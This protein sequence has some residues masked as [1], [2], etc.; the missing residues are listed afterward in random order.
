MKTSL[1][2]FRVFSVTYTLS[3][4]PFLRPIFLN[5]FSVSGATAPSR[6]LMKSFVFGGAGAPRK[7]APSGPRQDP[8]GIQIPRGAAARQYPTGGISRIYD[9]HCALLEGAYNCVSAK[10]HWSRKLYFWWA[11]EEKHYGEGGCMDGRCSD[12]HDGNIIRS[13]REKRK[14]GTNMVSGKIRFDGATD[15][16]S[17]RPRPLGVS[18]IPKSGSGR[19][20]NARVR[21]DLERRPS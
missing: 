5:P 7:F 16:C 14:T 6:G 13:V 8:N 20:G 1:D 18:R 17:P 9:R 12:T 4:V 21:R 2:G 3:A 11:R 15:I 10:S 19:I